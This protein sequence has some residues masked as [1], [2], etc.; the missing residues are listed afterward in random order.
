MIAITLLD[1]PLQDRSTAALSRQYAAILKHYNAGIA[2]L[3]RDARTTLMERAMSALLTWALE[4]MGFNV[5]GAGIHLV[6]ARKLSNSWKTDMERS[7]TD[8]ILNQYLPATLDYCEGYASTLVTPYDSDGEESN[9]ILKGLTVRE[10]HD[11][12]GGIEECVCAIEYYF[13]FMLPAVSNEG[14]AAEARRYAHRWK[15]SIIQFRYTSTT[16]YAIILLGYLSMG[17]GE[18]L[19]PSKGEEAIRGERLFVA[20][21]YILARA[22]DVAVLEMSTED[23][24]MRDRLLSLITAAEMPTDR[25]LGLLSRQTLAGCDTLNGNALEDVGLPVRVSGL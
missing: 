14:T 1:N 16:A 10:S 25:E 3:T 13:N 12:V 17:L 11:A 4:V 21:N 20:E 15:V 6:A 2:L 18:L 8:E 7:E 23:A 9:P 5:K 19:L 24:R 22:R